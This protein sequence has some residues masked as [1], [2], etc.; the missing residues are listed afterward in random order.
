MRCTDDAQLNLQ[1]VAGLAFPFYSEAR[2]TFMP[3]YKFD[4]GTDRYDTSEKAR[5]PAWTD[6]ILRKGNNIRQLSYDC[7][8]LKFSDHRPV[9]ATFRCVI[10]L[11]NEATREKISHELYEQ[12]KAEL[13]QGGTALDIDDSDDEDLIGYDAIEPGLP[14]A[15]SDRQRWWLEQG[16]MAQSGVSPPK[17]TNGNSTMILNP[18]RPSNP[19]TPTDESDWVAIPR[20]SSRLGSFSSSISSSPY[21]HINHSTL[22]STSA[23]STTPRKLPPPFDAANLPAK[24]GRNNLAGESSTGQ[25]FRREDAPPPPPPRRQTGTPSNQQATPKTIPVTA[26]K[27]V[28][29]PPQGKRLSVTSTNSGTSGKSKAPPPVARKPAH[30]SS[31]SPLTS[32][33][34]QGDDHFGG[35]ALRPELPRRASTIQNLTSKLEQHGSGNLTGGM[36][37]AS[38][39]SSQPQ[40][41]GIHPP[42]AGQTLES[43]GLS[44]GISL[45]GLGER[46][47]VLPTRPA[48]QQLAPQQSQP[49]PPS[50]LTRKPVVDLLGD[51]GSADEMNG[52]RTLRPV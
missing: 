35:T 13:G 42:S 12:R 2:I 44:G 37:K 23:L 18:N 34:L 29:P 3:T 38:P 19:F 5:I 31:T 43:K 49:M 15:S 40:R 47:P 25:A 50:K 24:A 21:E 39:P 16:K 30:L 28:A 10:S 4:I 17:P 7:A 8:P 46:K 45:P 27:P 52:W 20:A 1:M 11:V 14:P 48:V 33:S 36:Y 51:D 32:P 41:M 26:R 6:R 9:Y 22:L